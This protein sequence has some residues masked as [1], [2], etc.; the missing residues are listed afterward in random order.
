VPIRDPGLPDRTQ[1][2]RIARPS[3]AFGNQG[4]PGV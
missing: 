4:E 2:A 1:T 3:D